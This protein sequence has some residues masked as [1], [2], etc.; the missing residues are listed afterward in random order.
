MVE[1]EERKLRERGRE[2][3]SEFFLGLSEE[4]ESYFLV[5]K[6]L[7]SFPIILFKL[8]HMSPFEWNK[9]AHFFS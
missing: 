3:A 9:R 1:E 2:K 6:K 5:L 8:C 7:F 4:R